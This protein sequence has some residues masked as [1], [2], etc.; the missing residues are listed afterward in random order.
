MCPPPFARLERHMREAG[1]DGEKDTAGCVVG[2]DLSKLCATLFTLRN[3]SLSS[4]PLVDVLGLATR[5][6]LHTLDLQRTQVSNVSGLVTC[7]NLHT[8]DLQRTQVSNVSGLA[9]CTNLHTLLRSLLQ[10][11]ANGVNGA[12]GMAKTRKGKA[13]PAEQPTCSLK[14]LVAAGAG[15]VGAPQHFLRA[16]V[17]WV[18]LR[19]QHRLLHCVASK[20][21]L[22]TTVWVEDDPKTTR[23]RAGH[24]TRI[25]C[26]LSRIPNA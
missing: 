5:T 12:N 11:G 22:R 20:T 21:R 3:L 13:S 8:L 23:R 7:T 19:R 26:L 1:E 4:T 17:G 25:C 15:A 10:P 9:T 2:L 24:A 6:N 18:Q 14:D 16:R